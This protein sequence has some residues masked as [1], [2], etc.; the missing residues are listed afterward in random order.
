MRVKGPVLQV[1]NGNS[2]AAIKATFSTM[3]RQ[4]QVELLA[5]LQPS[6]PRLRWLEPAEAAKVV[7]ALPEDLAPDSRA[8]V[9]IRLLPP[10]M[11]RVR[12]QTERDAAILA[13][14]PLY[15]DEQSGRAI[16]TKIA[17]HCQR[18]PAPR[19]P[20]RE[21]IERILTANQGKAPGVTT[22]RNALAGLTRDSGRK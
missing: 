17:E 3:P 14:A 22:I 8:L 19:D 6:P 21:A 11:R 9:E 12:R 16:A 13:A 20:R 1:D 15:A 18:R 2:S 10:W 7:A 5:D 4:D